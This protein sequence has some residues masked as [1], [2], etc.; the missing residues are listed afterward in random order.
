M[1]RVGTPPRRLERAPRGRRQDVTCPPAK[2]Q[3]T[4]PESG[5]P[6]RF[7][8]QKEKTESTATIDT[9]RLLLL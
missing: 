1:W 5:E 4:I 9:D 7:H 2:L 8:M 3:H 6:L